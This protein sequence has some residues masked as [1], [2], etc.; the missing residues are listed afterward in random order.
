MSL[1]PSAT[2]PTEV[3][4]ICEE[5]SLVGESYVG[6]RY[7][8][9]TLGAWRHSR[10][11]SSRKRGKNFSSL[12]VLCNGSMQ[13]FPIFAALIAPLHDFLERVYSAITSR[14]KT[15]VSRVSLQVIAWGEKQ[16]KSFNDCKRALAK[17]VTLVHRDHKK[18]PSVYT[19]ASDEVRSGVIMQVPIEDVEKPHSEKRHE[20]L[21]FLSC[22]F[23][24]T[25]LRWSIL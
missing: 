24:S 17:Q 19:D 5:I 25:Q 3:H 7:N 6:K 11:W 15:A 23:D 12:H 20:P 14:K 13:A 16:E 22:R 2:A 9:S 4:I 10:R 8:V 18:R 21:A 1:A